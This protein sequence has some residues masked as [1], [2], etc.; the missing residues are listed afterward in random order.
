[1]S[2]TQPIKLNWGWS[3]FVYVLVLVATV[4]GGIITI[5]QTGQNALAPGYASFIFGGCFGFLV[6]AIVGLATQWRIVISI[7]GKASVSEGKL[8]GDITV[9]FFMPWWLFLITIGSGGLGG[10]VFW[11]IARI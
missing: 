5:V 4:V 7:G 11:L 8:K 9:L 6:F 3:I 1:M 10:L 2:Q